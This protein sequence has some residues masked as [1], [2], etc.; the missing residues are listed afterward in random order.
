MKKMT[1]L[2]MLVGR[3]A[4][5]PAG[6]GLV[7]AL[8]AARGRDFF[9]AITRYPLLVQSKADVGR[10]VDLV[11]AGYHN[12]NDR[13]PVSEKEAPGVDQHESLPSATAYYRPKLTESKH[14]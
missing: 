8:F 10:A 9:R 14:I 5:T 2:A 4:G 13:A 1:T 7:T 6:R 11:T 3:G 12:R